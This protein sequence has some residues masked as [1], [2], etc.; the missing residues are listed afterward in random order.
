[1][2]ESCLIGW[3]LILNA[4]IRQ[5]PC[6]GFYHFLGKQLFLTCITG[7]K[8]TSGYI[9]LKMFSKASLR[10]LP[11][12]EH[13]R[14][15]TDY[16]SIIADPLHP[17]M[18]SVCPT[19]NGVFQQDNIPYHKARIVLLQ[20][21]KN[22]GEFLLMPWLPNSP[23]LNSIEHIQDVMNQGLRAEKPH[24]RNTEK[25]CDCC[26]K[27]WYNLS[28]AIFQELMTSMPMRIAIVLHAKGGVT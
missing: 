19:R 18:A 7:Y 27:I 8:Q 5:W 10:P 28:P 17:Y 6:Q 21:K 26:L 13:N 16:P 1:M 23:N 22:V 2:E 4:G 20:F 15:A 9:I 12:V 24:L 14:K 25:L 11:V 3:I